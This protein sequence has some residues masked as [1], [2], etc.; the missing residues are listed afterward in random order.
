MKLADIRKPFSYKRNLPTNYTGNDNK[1]FDSIQVCEVSLAFIEFLNHVSVC[2]YYL[3]SGTRML[4]EFCLPIQKRGKVKIWKQWLKSKIFPETIIEEAIWITDTWSRNYFHWILECLPRLLA[5][6]AKGINAPLLIPEHIY[7]APY[8]RESLVDFQVEVITF[9]FRQTVKVDSLYLVSHD[10]P[11]AFDPEYIRNVIFKY[12]EI[13][14]P[15]FKSAS[16][17]IYISRKDA[18]KRKVENENELLPILSKYGFEILQ[19]ELLSFKEQRELM[20]ETKVLLSIHGAG[21]ANLI[22]MPENAKVIELHPD[23]ERYNSCFYHLAAALNR[24]YFY[25]F[26]KADHPNPQEAN[27]RVDLDKLEKLLL[28][29]DFR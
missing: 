20:R 25:S 12:Q 10:A 2:Q 17:R 16:R 9:N 8:V 6:Q 1:R 19:M 5:L 21:L 4:E 23:V 29:I 28:S 3:F 13:D 7:G 22:F 27:I 14:S 11:C 26:E 15:N 24:D 18:G